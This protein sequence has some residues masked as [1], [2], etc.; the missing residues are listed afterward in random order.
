MSNDKPVLFAY[1]KDLSRPFFCPERASSGAAGFDLKASLDGFPDIVIPPGERR[2][3]KT[4]LCVEIPKGMYGRIAPRSGLAYKNGI[5]VLAGVCDSDYRG[6]V[7]VILQNLDGRESYTVK[8]GDRVAQM[9]IEYCVV[10]NI[11]IR[12]SGDTSHTERNEGG[13]GSTGK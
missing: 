8:T 11:I 1:A 7:G 5:D 10:P 13:F 9:I 3:I 6:E 2:L 12:A 4:N